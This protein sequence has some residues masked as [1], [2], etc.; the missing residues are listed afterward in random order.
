MSN[1]TKKSANKN[2][3]DFETLDRADKRSIQDAIRRGWSRRD[4][5][6]M[7]MAFGATGTAAHQIFSDGQAANAATPK[8]GGSVRMA[9]NIHGPNDT[10]DPNLFTSAIDYTRARATYNGLV[11]ITE[12]L[13]PTPELAESFTPN[14][15]AT[16]WTF[17][18]RKGVTFHDGSPMTAEDVVYSMNRHLGDDSTSVLKPILASVKG[19][20][21][22]GPNEVKAEMHTANADLPST[23]GLY[24]AKIIKDGSRGGGN[25]TGP[26]VLE[27][28]DPGAKSVHKRNENYWREGANLDAIEMTAITDPVARVNA[29][30]AG[31]VQ[32]A[33]FIE[34]NSFRQVEN[35][36]TAKLLSVP[37]AQQIGICC[38]KSTDP[39]SNDDFVK[40]MQYIQDRER[41]VKRLLKGKGTIGNDTPVSPA[42]GKDWC[43][44]LPQR[45]FDPDKARFHF[46]KSGVSGAQIHVA[47]VAVAIED[48][49]LLAQANCAKIGFD[50]EIKKVPA[51]GYWGT[52][53]L[54]E[55][56]NVVNWN[57]RPTANAQ[58]AVQFAPGAPW[59]DTHWNNDRM[60]ELLSLSLSELD[61]E[62]RHAMYCEMQML[63]HE[64]SGIVVPA[65]SNTNDGL[66]NNV[67]GIPHV[68]IGPIGGGE[69]PEFVWLA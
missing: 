64:N 68:P 52:V 49:V 63:I 66:A 40:G 36:S 51:D 48:V 29:V 46:K 1:K 50:L 28:F 44:E 55:P 67:M 15:N 7:A 30:I 24:Q 60:G 53:W 19:W 14:S 3:L 26:F 56:I 39:G 31:D 17:K 27:S 69:W 16:E 11:Q 65:F 61:P 18:L 54:K 10:L 47:P 33:A 25:G 45:E 2:G 42:H 20:R 4:V 37:A 59:N 21:K 8:K 32:L 34:P 5:M 6:K 13:V 62:K 23:L 57:M 43:S 38:L 35:S 12:G 58:M 22:T 9:S 41:I